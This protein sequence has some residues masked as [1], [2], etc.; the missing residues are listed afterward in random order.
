VLASS[1]SPAKSRRLSWALLL[2][3][4]PM[5]TFMGHWPASLPLPGTDLYV[6]VP[7][8]GA[9][10]HA[11]HEDGSEAEH[12]KHCHGASA[13]CSDVPA[14]AGVSLAMLASGPA[15]VIAS[16]LLIALVYAAWRPG[17]P[18]AVS[19]GRRPPRLPALSV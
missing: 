14:A 17:V 15:F 11:G 8:A 10:H 4:V 18:L 7:L 5:L 6:S 9:E 3:L 1:H 2:A 19:P 13:S 16:A 12:A